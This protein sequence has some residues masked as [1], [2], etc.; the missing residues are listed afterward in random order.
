MIF[1]A[2]NYL[3]EMPFAGGTLLE[4]EGGTAIV[5]GVIIMPGSP[6][7]KE[8]TVTGVIVSKA[9]NEWAVTSGII[10]GQ[11]SIALRILN[12]DTR[13]TT[14]GGAVTHEDIDVP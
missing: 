14:Q 5:T 11:S 6:A 4:Y 8:A 12:Q 7:P 2:G 13:D 1:P 3:G 9:D 10:Q